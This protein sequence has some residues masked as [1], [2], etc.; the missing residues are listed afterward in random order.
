MLA[1]RADGAD[2]MFESAHPD[3]SGQSAR[4]PRQPEDARPQGHIAPSYRSKGVGVRHRKQRDRHVPE[5]ARSRHVYQTRLTVVVA[6]GP[7]RSG[8]SLS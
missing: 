6:D 3:Q 5:R 8:L 1:D 4:M 2:D 7:G